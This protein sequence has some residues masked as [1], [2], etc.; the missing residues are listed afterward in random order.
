V[1]SNAQIQ[2][3]FTASISLKI[4]TT[5]LMVVCCEQHRGMTDQGLRKDHVDNAERGGSVAK[6]VALL[7]SY[8]GPGEE[9]VVSIL[10]NEV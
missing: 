3:L 10:V 8:D 9:A 4:L 2:R 1:L 7:V 6:L 5:A